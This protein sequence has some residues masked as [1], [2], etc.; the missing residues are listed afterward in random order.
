MS[1]VSPE[2]K[3]KISNVS[4]LLARVSV[5]Y[6]ALTFANSLGAEDMVLT[7]LINRQDAGIEVFVLDTGRLHDETYRLLAKVQER[8]GLGIRVYYPDAQAV[9]AYVQK[10][11]INGFYDSVDSR[12]SCC[13]VRKVAP[14]KRALAGKD[15]WITG[16][17]RAQ[18]VTRTDLPEV[19]WDAGFGLTKINPLVDWSEQD[20]WDYL[21]AYAVPY[22]EL[23]DKHY[24]SIGCAPCTR[25]IA[26]G[27]D[28]RAGRWWWE[29]PESK[30]C[31][32]HVHKESV[33]QDRQIPV[34]TA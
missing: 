9:Q 28:V 6:P 17:R 16:L 30:E 34:Q 26:V 13:A 2:L 18:A 10:D 1:V 27:E 14:L 21:R 8:Y 7:D 5:E 19:E 33:H 29:N 31:G 3:Q 32:L 11:G 20:V 12:K 15:A 24:P 25:A 4:A 23:H 22:N